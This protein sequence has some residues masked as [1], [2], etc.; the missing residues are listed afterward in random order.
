MPFVKQAEIKVPS[1]GFFAS[2]F[3]SKP[4]DPDLARLPAAPT[5][6]F[7]GRADEQASFVRDVLAPTTPRYNILSISGE[8]G[9]G[10]TELLRQLFARMRAPEFTDYCLPAYVNE[11]EATLADIMEQ[12]A[13]QLRM[14]GDFRS[15]LDTYRRLEAGRQSALEATKESL[16]SS[17]IDLA[18]SFVKV[19]LLEQGVNTV[20]KPAVKS[21]AIGSMQENQQLKDAEKK[22]NS[23]PDLTRA[24]VDALNRLAAT[25]GKQTKRN[26][27]IVLFFDAFEKQASMLVPWLLNYLLPLSISDNVVLVVAAPLPLD[28][29]GMDNPFSWA[30]YVAE[31]TLHFMPLRVFNESET[32]EYL[33]KRGHPDANNVETILQVSG[34]LPVALQL[35]ANRP[36]VPFSE[37][38]ATV[39]DTLYL[40]GLTDG[41][42]KKLLSLSSALFSRPFNRDDV[43]AFSVL[44]AK[45]AFLPAENNACNELYGWLTG[46]DFLQ[47]LPQ[48]RYTVKDYV[49]SL[50]NQR[51]LFNYGPDRYFAIR[52]ALASYYEQLLKR[53]QGQKGQ[54]AFRSPEWAEVVSA[55]V[56]QLF[57]LQDQSGTQLAIE[58]I[59]LAGEHLTQ[60]DIQKLKVGLLYD[61]AHGLPSEQVTPE[62]RQAASYILQYIVSDLDSDEFLDATVFLLHKIQADP[63]CPPR[64]LALLYR[65][66][67]ISYVQRL[68][69]KEAVAYLNQ[70]EKL[71][72]GDPLIYSNRG[73]AYLITGAYQQAIEDMDRA[74][75]RGFQNNEIEASRGLAAMAL[76]KTD[77]ALQTFNAVLAS[78]PDHVIAL[79]YRA[80]L[81]QYL[82]EFEKSIADLDNVLKI[83][84]DH[85][86]AHVY[87][88]F[89]YLSL[90]DSQR[91]IADLNAALAVTP[92]YFLVYLARGI[93]YALLNESEPALADLN[94]AVDV[95]P[96]LLKTQAYT[97][98]SFG[99]Y[100]LNKPQEAFADCQR[101]LA[102]DPNLL[103]AYTARGFVYNMLNQPLKALQDFQYVLDR[104]PTL[105]WATLGRGAA[106]LASNQYAKAIPD[107]DTVIQQAPSLA[108]AYSN[109]GM[110]YA[111]LNNFEQALTDSNRALS[112][113]DKDALAYA[114]R[115]FIKAMMNRP[116]EAIED[117]QHALAL[118][119]NMVLAYIGLGQAYIQ[120]DDM[121]TALH[122][123]N[124]AIEQAPRLASPYAYRGFV[125]AL[126]G[127]PDDAIKD[128]QHAIELTSDI[129][130]A[131]LGLGIAY[132]AQSDA[133]QALEHFNRAVDIAPIPFA[134]LARGRFFL[135]QQDL[136]H[137]IEDFEHVTATDPA[138][139][140]QFAAEIASA[141]FNLGIVQLSH[142]EY[143]P[144]V[145]TFN[146]AIQ[147]TPDDADTLASRGEAHR[148]LKKYSPA[149][150]DFDHAL[151]L[152]PNDAWVLG[153]RG[154]VYSVLNDY[155]HA[156]EDFSK[157]IELSPDTL[158]LYY[159][160]ADAYS[161]AQDYAHAIADF[162]KW[163]ESAPDDAW[164]YAHRGDAYLKLNDYQS[165]LKDFDLAIRLK[166]D[167]IW[168]YGKRGHAN[169][170]LNQHTAAIQDYSRAIELGPDSNTWSY[171]NDRGLAYA[172]NQDYP[173]A[174]ADFSTALTWNP[175]AYFV[176]IERGN[177]Y[178]NLQDNQHAIED[179]SRVLATESDNIEA[180]L[181]RGVAYL[182]QSEYDN[183]IQ[184]YT[185]V[186]KLDPANLNA[187]AYRSFA[188][189]QQGEYQ[190]A[191]DDVNRVLAQEP[192]DLW[193]LAIRATAS[194]A[195]NN[196]EQAGAD[197]ARC[198]QLQPA[199]I[200]VGWMT[201]WIGMCQKTPGAETAERLIAIADVDPDHPIAFLCR[202][203]ANYL[204]RR[205]AEAATEIEQSIAR[206]PENW[207]G[208]FWAGLVAASS[209]KD[210][211]AKTAIE[212]ALA[213]KLPP[214]LLTPLRWLEQD[215]P[216]F[217]KDYAAPLLARYQ[218]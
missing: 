175:G 106:Y 194:L 42:P 79:T 81:Y 95:A 147:L 71:D 32:R 149:L 31:N 172:D 159:D 120:L 140:A 99:Y 193:L 179:F 201:E 121:E 84:P 6:F 29:Y 212:K 135:D 214:A 73:L 76:G 72:S 21:A 35:L 9:I 14:N 27:R 10:K 164:A 207:D 62:S 113:D 217:Y 77:Q 188:Y 33:A 57:L 198:W 74:I 25:Q 11:M 87:R 92:D 66:M 103:E 122:Y 65:D 136:Q 96:D 112:L 128:C 151:Q 97:T 196:L 91:A 68:E 157:A 105:I 59:L 55:L 154:L 83:D 49:Q 210:Q 78:N 141:Y 20:V 61:V 204:N 162:N 8:H 197:Y 125:Y 213:L 195:L 3:S 191:L 208:H 181:R 4:V 148:L 192:D 36:D 40:Q 44:P 131:H 45:F 89:A 124:Q 30:S 64:A 5:K 152:N 60:Q 185:D 117:C 174:I 134:Y 206:E 109:R 23:I 17:G 86:V 202:G 146:K 24:F 115:G 53:I 168:A 142:D 37:T 167:Y 177:A 133:Q 200:N 165:A 93:A 48:G 153:K 176:Y 156:I 187:Y 137:A 70:A 56:E 13:A 218:L 2:V 110:A 88:G 180:H 90:H 205:L 169:L 7:A 132:A 199:D 150:E 12:I 130:L 34:G 1:K 160:R 47:P 158:W 182:Q 58:Y 94:H 38:M 139:T 189:V 67:G 51:L 26:R 170:L 116:Q 80:I 50:F 161:N 114:S 104:A 216:A 215:Q 41:D 211:E 118:S 39:V 183:A 82:S 98:R 127:R 163:L 18:A 138:L 171:Y 100:F 203:A 75:E 69:Y 123:L 16:T 101:A 63:S 111:L 209:G 129:A 144:A 166:P 43:D 178:L 119:P 184:D 22:R 126:S 46:Q 108:R 173:H 102:L 85:P 15:A 28:Q 190:K 107:F 186:L 155:P 143:A 52:Q 19:P 54:G 145:E